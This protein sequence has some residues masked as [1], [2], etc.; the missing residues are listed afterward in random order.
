MSLPSE[1]RQQRELTAKPESPTPLNKGRHT[2]PHT[3]SNSH[4]ANLD[5][6]TS[7]ASAALRRTDVNNYLSHSP[8]ELSKMHPGQW[9]WS[10]RMNPEYHSSD[11]DCHGFRSEMDELRK[12]Q[13]A[14]ESLAL[15]SRSG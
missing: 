3:S 5:L 2:Q 11:P 14:I 4:S 15:L 8:R 13:E 7:V 9:R 1:S 6:L 10:Q 12:R